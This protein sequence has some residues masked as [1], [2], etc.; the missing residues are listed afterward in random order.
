MS[1]S[2][3]VPKV[4]LELLYASGIWTNSG[5]RRFLDGLQKHHA[6]NCASGDRNLVVE[7]GAVIVARACRKILRSPANQRALARYVK[8]REG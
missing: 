8:Q 5:C 6:A 3:S 4:Q 7:N 1:G 2:P